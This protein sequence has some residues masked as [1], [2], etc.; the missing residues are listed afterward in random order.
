[1]LNSILIGGGPNDAGTRVGEPSHNLTITLLAL[2]PK[3]PAFDQ[4]TTSGSC[5]SG[6]G[7][8]FP[9][10]IGYVEIISGLQWCHLRQINGPGT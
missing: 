4:D 8:H 5:L 1:M 2:Y 7:S 6:N 3:F 10:S 9:F